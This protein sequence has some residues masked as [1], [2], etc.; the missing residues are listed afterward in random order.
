MTDL[1]YRIRDHHHRIAFLASQGKKTGEI[2]E[3]TGL[4]IGR[5]SKLKSQGPIKELI[6]GYRNRQDAIE[7]DAFRQVTVIRATIEQLALEEIRDRLEDDPG[8]FSTREL[9]DL[10]ADAADRL[11]RSKV[12]R[13][14]SISMNVDLADSLAEARRREISL[15][16]SHGPP[17]DREVDAGLA[18]S[19]PAEGP[20]PHK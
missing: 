9:L 7:F 12:S 16:A 15:S 13:Q 8:K 2:A 17:H 19:S 20:A 14:E 1:N 3:A 5:V 4:S 18:T 10:S 11:G 6:E